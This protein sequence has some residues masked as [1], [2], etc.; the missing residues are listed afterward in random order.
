MQVVLADKAAVITGSFWGTSTRYHAAIRK[1]WQDAGDKFPV[2]VLSKG[3]IKACGSTPECAV[4]RVEA[5][6]EATVELKKH[7]S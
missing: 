4:V 3:E 1:A 2:M 5:G 7:P 6:D